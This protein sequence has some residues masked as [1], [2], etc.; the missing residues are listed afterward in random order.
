MGKVVGLVGSASGKIGNIVY[1]VTNGIQTARV[2]QPIISNPKTALQNAQRAKGNLAGRISSFTPRTALMGLGPN[3]RTR[4]GE[5]LKILLKNA[6]VE[7]TAD[8]FRAKIAQEQVA[9]SKGSVPL[10][11]IQPSAI[12]EANRLTIQL[13][14]NSSMDATTYAAMQTRIVL[15]LYSLESQELLAVITRMAEKPAM[16]SNSRTVFN[17]PFN[18]GFFADVYLIPMSTAD[19]SS[20]S[21]DTTLASQ[22][23]EEI[24]AAL[25]VNGNAVVFN[26]GKSLFAASGTY[27]PA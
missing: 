7:Q 20:V 26:Y 6:T 23:D 12:A 2:Y 24:Q 9:F 21:I 18:G 4:R 22:T 15:M 5:F 14:A 27:T 10:S 16:G 1:A 19:G 3:N 25:S 13:V 8:V 17:I 11:V